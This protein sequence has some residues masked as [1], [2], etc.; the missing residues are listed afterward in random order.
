MKVKD[1]IISRINDLV[2]TFP[3]F[4]VSYQID[5]Y[6]NSNYIKVTPREYFDNNLE[7]QKFETELIIDF[8]DKYPLDEIVFITDDSLIDIN[9]SIYEIE[10]ELFSQNNLA[11]NTDFWT[12]NIELEY[13]LTLNKSKNKFVGNYNSLSEVLNSFSNKVCI[14]PIAEE[15]SILSQTAESSYALAA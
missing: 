11:W 4:K 7:Y 10:G 5:D 8:I 9:N 2:S 15:P 1:Y 6:S 12:N 13:N 14:K 3:F